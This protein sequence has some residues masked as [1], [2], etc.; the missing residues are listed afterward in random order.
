M[1]AR[2][3]IEAWPHKHA[4]P[5]VESHLQ[6]ESESEITDSKKESESSAAHYTPRGVTTVFYMD[7]FFLVGL[8]QAR[9]FSES[10]ERKR[11]MIKVEMIDSGS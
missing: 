11:H 10:L 1:A 4:L 2:I 3:F 9:A 8:F 5:T 7:L 6:K